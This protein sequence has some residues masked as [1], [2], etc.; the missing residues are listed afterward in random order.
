MRSSH[1]Q[2]IVESFL[3]CIIGLLRHIR[4]FIFNFLLTRCCSHMNVSKEV[5]CWLLL[6]VDVKRNENPKKEECERPDFKDYVLI[7]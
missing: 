1:T 2:C 4:A 7:L 3:V 6:F 5:L